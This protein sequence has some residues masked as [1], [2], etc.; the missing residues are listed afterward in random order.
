MT[1]DVRRI[2][3]FVNFFSQKIRLLSQKY[4][5]S[6]KVAIF[7]NCKNVENYNKIGQYVMLN[8]IPNFWSQYVVVFYITLQRI[9]S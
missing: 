5:Y 9:V 3:Y 4:W 6:I 8:S 7:F 1:C 2:T